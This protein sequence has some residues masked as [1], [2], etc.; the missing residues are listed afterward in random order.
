MHHALERLNPIVRKFVLLASETG[1][2]PEAAHAAGL[3]ESQVA[4]LLPRL[5]TFL[6]PILH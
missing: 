4:L 3:N 2:V 1:D 6:G 5:K